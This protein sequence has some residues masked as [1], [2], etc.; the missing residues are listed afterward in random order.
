MKNDDV[1]TQDRIRVQ[2]YESGD[3]SAADGI[4]LSAPFA[5]GSASSS[6]VSFEAWSL[7]ISLGLDLGVSQPVPPFPTYSHIFPLIFQSRPGYSGIFF[8]TSGSARPR[9]AASTEAATTPSQIAPKGKS[10]GPA[11]PC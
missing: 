6:A 8:G 1:K 7:E 4:A 11:Y 10:A 5:P 3:G 9:N 2:P